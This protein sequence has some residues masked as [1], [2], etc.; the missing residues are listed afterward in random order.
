MKFKEVKEEKGR[1]SLPL[2]VL[3]F[4][5]HSFY[6]HFVMTGC[7]ISYLSLLMSSRDL[8]C[9]FL[10]KELQLVSELNIDRVCCSR[11]I[12]SLDLRSEIE[13]STLNNTLESL[14]MIKK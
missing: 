2:E 1:L 10:K 4:C 11:S 9:G 7:L 14:E 13:R 12:M 8:A 6:E 5:V 3:Y